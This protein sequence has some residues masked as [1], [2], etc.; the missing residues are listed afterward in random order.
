MCNFQNWTHAHWFGWG[1]F[2]L[3]CDPL[4]KEEKAAF[5]EF[6]KKRLSKA[7]ERID[8]RISQLKAENSESES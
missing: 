1:P 3:M 5:L 7:I 8:E 2:R 4:T 6:M